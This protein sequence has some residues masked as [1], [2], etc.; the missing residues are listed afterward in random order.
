MYNLTPSIE[1]KRLLKLH[2]NP[3]H[4]VCQ[5]KELIQHY[6]AGYTC[7]DNLP[8]V[9]STKDN[10]DD[11]LFPPGHPARSIN[12]TYYLDEDIVLRS[13]TSA[14]QN[15]LLRRGETRFLATGEVYRKDTIDKSHYPVFHQME[16]I[17]ILLRGGDALKDL[18]VTL[19]GLI[20]YLFPGKEYRFLDDSF[21]YTS[22][23]LQVEVKQE[24]GWMEVLGGGVIHSKILENCKV[25]GTGWAFGLGIDR[26]V[27]TRCQVP[28]IRYLWT[29]DERFSKQFKKGLTL[30]K[31]Y[32]KYPAVTRDISFWVPGYLSNEEGLWQ[33]HNNFCELCRDMAED[34][35]ES[36]TI[37]DQ[38]AKNGTVSLAYRIVYRSNDRTLLNEEI[39][40]IQHNIRAATAQRFGVTLR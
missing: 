37:R 2:N 13:H 8:E 33:Q 18:K 29:K 7:F 16:G 23:S 26:L 31:E 19:T 39:N 38:Y 36:V 10:F 40:G 25:K 11:L 32:S 21:P 3:G 14:H 15:E 30:F 35:I 4:P 9:V 6:F 17:K 1:E 27:L 22:P 34:L 20:Q 28:D 12:D 24:D 5:M